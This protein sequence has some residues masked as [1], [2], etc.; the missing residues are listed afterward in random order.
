MKE[1]IQVIDVLNKE[2]LKTINE[3]TDRIEY[4]NCKVLDNK[5]GYEDGS[6]SGRTSQG[7]H[8]DEDN[9]V[10]KLLHNNINNALNEYK[11]RLIKIDPIFSGFP[12]PGGFNTECYRDPIQILKYSKGQEYKFHHDNGRSKNEKEYFRHIS[13]IL[14]LQRATKGGGTSFIHTTLKPLA[15]QAII[16]PSNWCYPHSGDPV[17]EGIKKVA[18]TWYYSII[19]SQIKEEPPQETAHLATAAASFLSFLNTPMPS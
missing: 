18:V 11:K 2:E 4:K 13:V 8:L 6:A 15:G 5:G 7:H 9:G 19:R 10:T 3:Y 16:F 12:V 1:L 14:Y 17:E